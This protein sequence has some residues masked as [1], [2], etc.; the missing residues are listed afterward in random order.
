MKSVFESMGGTYTQSGDY[1]IP[2]IA[3][4]ETSNRRIGKYGRMRH[5]YLK[6][7]R[8]V[9][10][11]TMI[12]DGTLWDHLAEIDLTCNN[13]LDVLISGMRE[14]QGITENLKA[15]DPM[16]WVGAMNNIRSC[17]EE[18]VLRELVYGEDGA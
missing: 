13:Q 11:S 7:H 10:Y 2:E 6:E 18:V 15:R 5:R 14:K 17:A 16:A 3:L 12:L 8:P 9:L 1:F 4:P